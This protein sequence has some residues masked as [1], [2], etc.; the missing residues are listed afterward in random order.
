MIFFLLLWLDLSSPPDSFVLIK[1]IPGELKGDR[2]GNETTACLFCE[3]PDGSGDSPT[4]CNG[5]D[6]MADGSLLVSDD[7][8]GAIY[9]ITYGQ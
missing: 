7:R 9:R 4:N 3:K 5:R 8:A 1:M 6:W 2:A